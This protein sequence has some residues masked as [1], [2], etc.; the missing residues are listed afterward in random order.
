[1]GV[2]DVTCRVA[3]LGGVRITRGLQILMHLNKA[4]TVSLN[5]ALA[6]LGRP[7]RGR[8]RLLLSMSI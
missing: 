2:K 5:L 8:L 7:P 6:Q 1:M 4:G 3:K